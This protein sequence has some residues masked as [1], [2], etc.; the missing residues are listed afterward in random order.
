MGYSSE[1]KAALLKRMLPLDNVTIRQLS[2]GEGSSEATLHKWRAKACG[3]GQL[4]PDSDTG[5]VGW[6]SH[7]KF[8]T[9]TG[10]STFRRR[11]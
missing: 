3:K 1:C 9:V 5:P 10:S 8:A 11:A 6:S 4:L 7:D 2:R